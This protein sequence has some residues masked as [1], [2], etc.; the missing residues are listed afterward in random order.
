MLSAYCPNTVLVYETL[1][2]DCWMLRK[3]PHRCVWGAPFKQRECLFVLVGRGQGVWHSPEQVS[4]RLC[5]TAI[6]SAS[7]MALDG[8]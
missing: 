7:F 1:G 5:D 2:T 6:S 3:L 4:W 8:H